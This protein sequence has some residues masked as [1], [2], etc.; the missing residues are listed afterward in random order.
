MEFLDGLEPLLKTYWY[1]A[2]PTS[3]IFIIQT[4]MTFIG[5]DASDGIEADFDG[6]LDGAEGP[7][8]YL[9]LRNLINFLL[10]FDSMGIL[11]SPKMES[12]RYFILALYGLWDLSYIV[13]PPRTPRATP[14]RRTVLDIILFGL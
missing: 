3:L 4:L 8:Q 11:Y 13:A 10:G 2:L 5:V 12:E 14:K 6:D 1:I 9:S 7:M